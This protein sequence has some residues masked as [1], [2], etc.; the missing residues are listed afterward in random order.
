MLKPGW[1]FGIRF[2]EIV[3][4]LSVG[5]QGSCILFLDHDRFDLTVGGRR[6]LFQA[7]A[8]YILGFYSA[9]GFYSGLP[10][11]IQPMG[12]PSFICT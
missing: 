8:I 2:S 1:C 7:T 6:R 5:L 4:I 3:E 9:I 12:T 11:I 10:L